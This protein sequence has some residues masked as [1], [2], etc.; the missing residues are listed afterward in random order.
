MLNAVVIQGRL[1]RDPER[2]TTN[3]GKSYATFSLA[4]QRDAKGG[5]EVDWFNVVAWEHSADFVCQWFH[6]GDMALVRGRLQT[7]RYT[8]RDGVEKK[9]TDIIADHVYF[10]SSRKDAEAETEAAAPPRTRFEPLD[11]DDAQLPF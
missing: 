5:D 9:T 11:E 8:G 1:G 7:G 10:S 3:T 6:K 4:C 2:K